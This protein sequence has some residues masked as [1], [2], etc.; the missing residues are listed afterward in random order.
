MLT[1]VSAISHQMKPF[2]IALSS[3]VIFIVLIL[4]GE[5]SSMPDLDLLSSHLTPRFMQ[6]I[7]PAELMMKSSAKAVYQR[8]KFRSHIVMLY[9]FPAGLLKHSNSRWF[10]VKLQL[11]VRSPL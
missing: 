11:Q 5:T 9:I 4:R 3:D 8:S 2:K 7:K 10:C 1:K 6:G